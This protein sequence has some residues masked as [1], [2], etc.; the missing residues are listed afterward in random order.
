MVE[1]FRPRMNDDEKAGSWLVAREVVC[2]QRE[3]SIRAV[4]DPCTMG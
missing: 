1:H 2:S 3:T 4:R